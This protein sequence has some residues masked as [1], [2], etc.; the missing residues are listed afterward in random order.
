MMENKNLPKH[1]KGYDVDA[2]M[3]K[4]ENGI[5]LTEK[6]ESLFWEIM[7]KHHKKEIDILFQNKGKMCTAPINPKMEGTSELNGALP[8]FYNGY[9]VDDI[10]RKYLG[11]MELTAEESIILNDVTYR[12]Y[13]GRRENTEDLKINGIAI[14]PTR[15]TINPILR[16]LE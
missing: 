7:Q 15:S 12:Y 5:N 1:Y 10:F 2:I 11:N 9:D 14:H 3:K 13:F 6:E 16:C 8:R 4:C